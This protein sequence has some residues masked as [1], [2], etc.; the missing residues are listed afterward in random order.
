MINA[1]HIA[2]AHTLL[3]LAAFGVALC[4]GVMLHYKKIVKNGVA[5]YPEEWFPS[6]SA[7]YVKIPVCMVHE[8]IYLCRIGDWYPE[9][10]LFQILIALT[11]GTWYYIVILDD[12]QAC[13]FSIGPRFALVSLQYYLHRSPTS[14]LPT[15]VFLSGLIRTVSC[16]GWVYITSS[17]DH[18]VHDFFMITY[19]VFNIPWMIGSIACTPE[20]SQVVRRKRFYLTTL[21]GLGCTCL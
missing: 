12:S 4:V 5:G 6:V 20:D 17:D 1:S 14:S 7:T 8:L 19:I 13:S 21:F 18:D 10:N 9:R 2:R 3:A 15:V 16:G 11:S